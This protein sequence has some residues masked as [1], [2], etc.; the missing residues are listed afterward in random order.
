MAYQFVEEGAIDNN[1]DTA[2]NT[3]SFQVG[4]Q[5]TLQLGNLSADISGGIAKVK[6]NGVLS[7]T[8]LSEH[9]SNDSAIWGFHNAFSSLQ[10]HVFMR[11]FYL[12]AHVSEFL[13]TNVG[14]SFFAVRGTRHTPALNIFR[15]DEVGV[16]EVS[17]R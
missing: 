12:S 2:D 13:D 1:G 16:F 8:K 5:I 10:L 11:L 15:S 17:E 7:N 14:Q 6:V 3:A 4:L 9:V